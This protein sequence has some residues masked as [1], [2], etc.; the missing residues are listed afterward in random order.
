MCKLLAE[1]GHSVGVID[2]LSTGHKDALKWGRQFPG[3]IGNH[4]LLKH[5][6]SSFKPEGV[7]HFAAKSLVGESGLDPALYYQNNVRC[8]LSL[9]DFMKERKDVPFVF[10]STAAVYGKPRT[11]SIKESHVLKPI[12]VYGRTKL[13]IEHAIRDYCDAYGMSAVIFRYFNAAGADPSGVIGE[14]HN[15]ETHLIPNILRAALGHS[16]RVTV[17]GDDYPTA[18][19]TC[20]RDY[21]HV[22][23]LCNAH[24]LGLKYAIGK[25]GASVFN[26]GSQNGFSVLDVIKAS[27]EVI[28]ASIPYEISDRRE[29]DPDRLVADSS[30]A[31]S[32]LGWSAETPDLHAIIESAW[33]WH[34]H[35]HG[36]T[37]EFMSAWE[38]GVSLLSY[39][40][41][42]KPTFRA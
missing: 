18:D 29:G 31:Q 33:K 2:D 6:F 36:K 22:N 4:Q 3:S 21:I 26:L 39:L 7:L 1:H 20:V 32:I 23:D 30:R 38:R 15:P 17:Y 14:D 13:T 34:Q 5:V 35:R 37:G 16:A 40:Q 11:F 27:C 24:L 8:S 9:L 42:L 10:S 41:S 28:G 12:N 25:S 19:G